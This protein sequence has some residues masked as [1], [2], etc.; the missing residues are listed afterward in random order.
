M[1]LSNVDRLF[2]M[3]Q[4]THPER[5]LNPENIGPN[6]NVFLEDYQIVDGDTQ[7]LPFRKPDDNGFWTTNDV[8]DTRIPRQVLA[9]APAQQLQICIPAVLA[10]S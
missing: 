7:L 9:T 2:S 3:Y 1:G 8:Q 4:S 5:I 10:P 6:G